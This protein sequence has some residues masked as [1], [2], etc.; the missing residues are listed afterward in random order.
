LWCPLPQGGLALGPDFANPSHSIPLV[1]VYLIL[2][3][4]IR[5][6]MINIRIARKTFD[7]LPARR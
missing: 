6:Y 3:K 1:L 2:K 5:A 4:Y 7:L